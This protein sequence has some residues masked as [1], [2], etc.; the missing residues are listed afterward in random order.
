MSFPKIQLKRADSGEVVGT[1]L[2]GEPQ[3]LQGPWSPECCGVP[4]SFLGQI[5]TLDIPARFPDSA[6]VY[7][8]VC[9]KCFQT[10]SQIQCC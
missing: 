4:M 10:D 3:W 5:D 1:H 8:F 2:G 7:V 9:G 6:I